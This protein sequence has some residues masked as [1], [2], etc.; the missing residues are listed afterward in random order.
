MANCTNIG[1]AGPSIVLTPNPLPPNVPCVLTGF[2]QAFGGQ[3]AKVLNGTTVL[4]QISAPPLATGGVRPMT[5]ASGPIATFIS[6]ASAANI[7]VQITNTGS[8]KSQVVTSYE[9]V[10]WGTRVYTGQWTFA[11]DD[12]AS[13]GDC[14]FNDAVITLTW[15][16]SIG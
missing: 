6:P 10:T 15:T 11:V 3:T 2:V 1:A 16:S 12:A 5:P 14:D 13:G 8:Q 4:A 7:T 9:T